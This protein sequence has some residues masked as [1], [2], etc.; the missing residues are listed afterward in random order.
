MS[1][2]L[3]ILKENTSIKKVPGDK[4][5]VYCHESYAQAL[6]DMLQGKPVHVKDVNPGEMVLAHDLKVNLKSNAV[7]IHTESG[8][9]IAV[10]IRREK[11]Y[12][13]TIGFEEIDLE[14]ISEL[15]LS[16]WFRELFAERS[17]MVKIEGDLNNLRGSIYEAYQEKTREEF[18]REIT[19]PTAYYLAKVISKNQGGFFIK[20]RGIDAFL[21]GS[22][23]A[24]NKIVDFDAYIGREVPVM[25]EDYLKQSDTF[26]F[27]Y[28]KYLEKILPSK[29]AE[30]QRN[31]QMS[32]IITGSSKYGIFVEFNEMFT[33]LLHTSE[34]DST[35]LEKFNARKVEAGTKMNVWV[36][37]IRDNKLILTEMD[38]AEKQE[39]IENFKHKIEGTVKN[40]KVV[41][42]KLFGAFFEV[43]EG[44]IG[45]LP[46]R[47]LK[48]IAKKMEVGESYTLCIS[49]VDSETG[50]IYLSALNEKVA[51]EV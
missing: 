7:E 16:G 39:E 27:S 4:C 49:K 29:L 50:K 48:R 8:L 18:I 9:V 31:S 21:P 32:G 19:A 14:R 38:P 26:I 42:V 3:R 5:K 28:K 37:D 23:A 33:G 15:S 47:E 25:V 40:M 30:I 1:K 44:K 22:L 24:A 43:E 17:E 51:H 35:T 12:F 36:K 45:L 34:M 6:Y 10:D 46:V 11:K 2:R 41:S 20:V 13:E